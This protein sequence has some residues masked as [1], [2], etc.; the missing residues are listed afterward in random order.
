MHRDRTST[1]RSPWF[2]LFPRSS[3]RSVPIGESLYKVGEPVCHVFVI[4]SGIVAELRHDDGHTHVSCLCHPGMLVGVRWIG[5]T[6]HVH[7]VEAMALSELLLRTAPYEVYLRATREDGRYTSAALSDMS[8]RVNSAR[9]LSDCLAQPSTRDHVMSVLH[10]IADEYRAN[11]HALMLAAV[12]TS[13]L[14]RLTG[15]PI[16]ALR[17]AVSELVAAGHLNTDAHGIKLPVEEQ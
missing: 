5:T 16:A 1:D 3:R 13:I 9:R 17:S 15:C 12:P 4:E 10:A 7:A 6:D 2:D 11:D 14:Q 8:K